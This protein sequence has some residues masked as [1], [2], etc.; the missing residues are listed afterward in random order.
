MGE[1]LSAAPVGRRLSLCWL[2]RRELTAPH[3]AHTLT[4]ASAWLWRAKKLRTRRPRCLR[5][6]PRSPRPT[7][8]PGM[9]AGWALACN[10]SGT[11]GGRSHKL[12]N[13]TTCRHAHQRSADV[14]MWSYNI[15]SRQNVNADL[16]DQIKR[17]RCRPARL[18]LCSHTAHC[19]VH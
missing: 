6:T 3:S 11:R 17:S 14:T 16:E 13:L 5:T 10:A 2:Y 12:N 15:E 4:C 1:I 18:N 9:C 8:R 7:R 19:F